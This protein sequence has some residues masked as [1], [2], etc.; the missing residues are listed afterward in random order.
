MSLLKNLIETL[1][2]NHSFFFHFFLGLLLYL[3]SKKILFQ[4]YLKELKQKEALS[5]GRMEN[6]KKINQD[7]ESQKQLYSQKA[8]QIH[9]EFKSTFH[10]IKEKAQA[11]FLKESQSLKKEQGQWIKQGR[12]ALK[13]SLKEQEQ[14][15]ENSFPQ[16]TKL[17]VEKIKQ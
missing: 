11:Q 5:K 1:G 16:L 12:E 4:P 7:L 14:S 8:Q 17:L 2:L 15:L 10:K 3:V 6:I 13:Q 9:K